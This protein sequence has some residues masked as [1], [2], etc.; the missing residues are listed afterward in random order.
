M[1]SKPDLR[2]EGGGELPREFLP[3]DSCGCFDVL[4]RPEEEVSA[5]QRPLRPWLE[6]L[7]IGRQANGAAEPE[8]P[9]RR[10]EDSLCEKEK[11]QHKA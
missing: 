8:G 4:F 3:G 9:A 11:K 1:V 7:G 2:D 10:S 6:H 5:L